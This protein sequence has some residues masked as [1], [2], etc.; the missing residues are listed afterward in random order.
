RPEEGEHLFMYLGVGEATLS[1]VLLKKEAQV[2]KP[3]YYVSK[4]LQ[5]AES[6]YSHVDKVVLALIMTSRK[7]RPYFQAHS[8]TILTDQPLRQILQKPEYSGRLTKW[9]VELGEFDIH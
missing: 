9:V 8:I 4:V 7:L 2:D 5:D 1:A 3:I 6:R